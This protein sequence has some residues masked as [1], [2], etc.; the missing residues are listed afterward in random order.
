MVLLYNISWL[1]KAFVQNHSL[2][3]TRLGGRDTETVISNAARMMVQLCAVAKQTAD[4]LAEFSPMAK[5]ACF[6]KDNK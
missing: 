5:C 1:L 6:F 4:N 2:Q 3:S